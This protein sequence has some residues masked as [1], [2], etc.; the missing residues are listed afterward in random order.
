MWLTYVEE[1]LDQG[2][3]PTMAA[4]TKKLDNFII[5]NQWRLLTDR[6]HHS[7]DDANAHALQQLEIYRAQD[8]QI[9]VTKPKKLDK[10]S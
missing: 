9:E 7:R 10:K 1:Q 8:A 2:R 3:L 4:V 5:F 6:G